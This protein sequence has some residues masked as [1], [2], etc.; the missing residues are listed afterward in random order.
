MKMEKS[1][2]GRDV[3]SGSIR[4]ETRERYRGRKIS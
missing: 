3:G 4:G 1:G 2:V